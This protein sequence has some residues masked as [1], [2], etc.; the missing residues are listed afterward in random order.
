MPPK[1][2]A[3]KA[4]ETTAF[5]LRLMKSFLALRSTLHREELVAFAERLV[6]QE[7]KAPVEPAD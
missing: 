6:E 4:D 2:A 1:P 7:Q 5:G 3:L